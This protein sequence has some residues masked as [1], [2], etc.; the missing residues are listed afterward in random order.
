MN[1]ADSIL[2]LPAASPA[3]TRNAV[4]PSYRPHICERLMEV[5]PEREISSVLILPVP[6]PPPNC[7]IWA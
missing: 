7:A 1:E 6:F 2:A 3:I 5:S 4:L